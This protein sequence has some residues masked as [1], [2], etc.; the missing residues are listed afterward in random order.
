M[1]I[2][3]NCII[4]FTITYIYLPETLNVKNI[5]SNYNDGNTGSGSTGVTSRDGVKYSA[6]LTS[7]SAESGNGSATD[8]DK[9]TDKNNYSD[10]SIELTAV[11]KNKMNSEINPLLT[12]SALND[13]KFSMLHM[14][15]KRFSGETDEESEAGTGVEGIA[16]VNSTSKTKNHHLHFASISK[17]G[18]GV[19]LKDKGDIETG[20]SSLTPS[21]SPAP[22]PPRK[23]HRRNISFSSR[24]RVKVIDHPDISYQDLKQVSA[25]EVPLLEGG[26]GNGT[27]ADR[28]EGSPG[29]SEDDDSKSV[30]S[31]S[32]GESLI[33]VVRYSNG[34]EFFE[35]VD[36]SHQSV[37][38]NL[39]Y[40][41]RQR[42]VSV[43]TS[44]YGLAAF[45]VVIVNEIFTLWIVTSVSDG[46]L[47]YNTQQIGTAI[48][49][50]GAFAIILQ[51]TVYPT[52]VEKLG[53]LAVHRYGGLMFAVNSVFIPTLGIGAADRSPT[54]T[55]ALVVLVLTVQAVAVNWYLI[56]T[57]VLISN[58]CYSHQLATVNGIGQTCASIG[59]LSG[60]YLGSVLF[61][62]S[63]TNG[64]EWPFNQY[65]VF[66][67]SAI[68]A[69][70][71]YQYSLY[72]PRSIQR[73][74]REPKFRTWDEADEYLRRFQEQQQQQQLN[75]NNAS[76]VE[77]CGHARN[78]LQQV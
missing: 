21:P 76:E 17:E 36:S 9:D 42:H 38:A 55:L 48:M 67:V 18:N 60:P 22:L 13:H 43:A 3:V 56:S 78:T 59:R 25:D 11:Q 16:S 71:I 77:H 63:E 41:L 12:E 14:A 51:L 7:D 35:S 28:S 15:G 2:C 53:V 70:M 33:P 61:A 50:C 58:S 29:L 5:E 54:A 20:T 6:L 68:L 62:W 40:L 57:F 69:V 47:D 73:R 65:F 10:N 45:V 66:Y 26:H 8:S 37:W 4:M 34:S 52:A 23:G 44:L 46:G 49:I 64:L 30:D 19:I 74:K 72:L 1:I 75:T 31:S 32:L 39:R 24:V 27:R